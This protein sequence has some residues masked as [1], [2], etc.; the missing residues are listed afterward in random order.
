[1]NKKFR[2]QETPYIINW[3][4][5]PQ[6]TNIGEV[7]QTAIQDVLDEIFAEGRPNDVVNVM[8]DHDA[9][10][11][12]IPLPFTKQEKLTANKIIRQI[13]KVQQ[14]RRELA[15]DSALR[16]TFARMRRPDKWN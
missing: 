10:E 8:I 16:L 4:D 11:T 15:F 9:L 5:M 6:T 2:L 14:S 1:M 3:K 7:V 13:Q 12:P